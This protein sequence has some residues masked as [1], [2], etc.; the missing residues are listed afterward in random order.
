MAR[1][2]KIEIRNFRAIKEFSWLPSPGI[3][4]LIGPGGSGKSSVLD[5]IDACLGGARRNMQF[6][7][8]D[9]H[10]LD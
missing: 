8:A 4:C 6:T 9:F 5:A 1:L 7:D 3:N 10:N 2:R